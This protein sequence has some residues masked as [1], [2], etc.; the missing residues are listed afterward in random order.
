MT[1]VALS[2]YLIGWLWWSYECASFSDSVIIKFI[3]DAGC[4][5]CQNVVCHFSLSVAQGDS[6]N[7]FKLQCYTGVISTNFSEYISTDIVY[8]VLLFLYSKYSWKCRLLWVIKYADM[9][10]VLCVS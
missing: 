9:S 10:D 4:I 7:I 6:M 1:N 5:I 8:T 2:K 3:V